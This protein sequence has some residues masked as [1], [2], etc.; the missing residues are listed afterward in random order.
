[1]YLGADLQQEGAPEQCRIKH[2]RL[3]AESWSETC[4]WWTWIGVKMELLKIEYI[5]FVKAS[6]IETGTAWAPV[7]A[8]NLHLAHGA[9]W[10]WLGGTNPPKKKEKLANQRRK[11]LKRSQAP[12]RTAGFVIVSHFGALCHRRRWVTRRGDRGLP[13]RL[14]RRPLALAARKGSNVAW[15]NCTGT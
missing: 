7:N 11:P 14:W 3:D 13:A 5:K 2:K 4:E 12:W 8:A 6:G 1:M 9:R 15:E 10:N